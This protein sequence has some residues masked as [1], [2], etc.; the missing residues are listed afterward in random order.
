MNN[1][2][3][4][5]HVHTLKHEKDKNVFRDQSY[6]VTNSRTT[7]D[8]SLIVLLPDSNPGP[9]S[10]WFFENLTDLQRKLFLGASKKHGVPGHMQVPGKGACSN[11]SESTSLP[12]D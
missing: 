8:Y 6:H 11:S 10:E 7:I 3:Q 2:G 1:F 9:T 12:P 5:V 4:A